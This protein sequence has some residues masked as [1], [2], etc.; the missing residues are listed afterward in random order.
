VVALG[1]PGTPATCWARAGTTASCRTRPAIHTKCVLGG[2]RI[3]I[4]LF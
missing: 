4:L 2:R 3:P 1:E